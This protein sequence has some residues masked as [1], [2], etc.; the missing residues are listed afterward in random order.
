MSE[1]E[2]LTPV[3]RKVRDWHAQGVKPRVMAALLG[4][5]TQRVYTVLAR[6]RE[7]GVIE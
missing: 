2:M 6:L 5:S 4:C 7:M 3:Q 1:T